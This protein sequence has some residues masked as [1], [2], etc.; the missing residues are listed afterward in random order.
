[1]SEQFDVNAPSG[2]L[3]SGMVVSIDPNN[4]GKLALS[5][6]AYD[7]KVAGI[8][9]GAGGISTGMLMGQKGSEENGKLP[10]A[11]TGREYC[12]VEASNGPI[13]AGE[14]LTTSD[15]PGHAIKVTDSRRSQSAIL[16]KAITDL[17]K[18]KGFVL[19]LVTLQ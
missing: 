4:P 12:W 9:S 16:R 5:S 7:R 15:T 3:E 10:I 8:I 6:S 18:D 11:L 19:I 13:E 2:I 1:M 17:K 14:L